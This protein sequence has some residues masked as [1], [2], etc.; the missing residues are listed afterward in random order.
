LSLHF[1]PAAQWDSIPGMPRSTNRGHVGTLGSFLS[2]N[3]QL[4]L[5]CNAE[6]CG[7]SAKQD[8]LAL[9]AAHGED[10]P[11]QQLV[12]RARCLRCGQRQV[13]VT[14]PPDLGETG[15]FRYPDNSR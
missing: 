4:W 7:R 15:G 12:E 5:C 1:R 10:F 3:R 11:L 8:V 2:E 13:S 14:A 9:I 6:G